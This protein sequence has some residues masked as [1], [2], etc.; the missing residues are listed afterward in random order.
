MALYNA[1]NRGERGQPWRVPRRR[2]KVLECVALVC[3][4]ATG[5]EY[6]N[7]IHAI[8]FELKPNLFK[9]KNK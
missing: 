5:E 4:D 1:N 6:N 7:Q 3:T 9:M 2:G 8:K